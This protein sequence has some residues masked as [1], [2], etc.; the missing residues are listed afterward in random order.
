MA[1]VLQEPSPPFVP[2]L[3]L[4]RAFFAE[5]VRPLLDEAYPDLRYAAARLGPGSDVLGFDTERSVDHDWGPRLELFLT[6]D[7]VDRYAEPLSALLAT[8]LPKR[9]RGWSTHFEPP[10]GRIRT[11][12]ATDGPV[13]HRVL[14]TDVG[15]WCEERLGFDPRRGVTTFDWLATP[16]QRLNEVTGGAVFHDGLAELGAVRHALGRYPEDVWR[17]LLACQWLRIAEEEAFVGRAAEAGDEPGSRVVAARLAREVMR[18]SLLLA[19]RFPPYSKW[20]GSAFAALPEAVGIAAAL[21]EA[22]RVDDA[23][24]RQAALCAAYEAAGDWQNRLGLA[25]PVDAVRRPFFD[26]PYP[27]IDAARFTTALLARVEDPEIAAL[28]PVGGIDQYADS[29]AVLTRPRLARALMM[30][31]WYEG[32]GR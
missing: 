24:R 26:R 18:L 28:P 22:L 9:V 19:G 5:A 15:S 14:I 8:R 17:Y 25:E 32:N 7:D 3:R 23:A 13:A 20:L 16:G 30:A 2:G 21:D 4:C 10:Q 11:M 1:A 29:T 31:A 12:A 6:A 27:V